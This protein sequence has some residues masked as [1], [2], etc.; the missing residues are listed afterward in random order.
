MGPLLVVIVYTL[1]PRA[2]AVWV[3]VQSD[4]HT[5][6]LVA[7]ATFA[8]AVLGGVGHLVYRTGVLT[9]EVKSLRTD[10]DSLRRYVW[11]SAAWSRR[12]EPPEG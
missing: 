5:Q 2:H 3:D 7:L 1:A 6:T 12:Q 9:Q 4:Q 8:V 11:P 10:L